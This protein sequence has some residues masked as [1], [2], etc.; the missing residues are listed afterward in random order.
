MRYSILACSSVIFICI[1]HTNIRSRSYRSCI[2]IILMMCIYRTSFLT[3]LVDENNRLF[4]WTQFNRIHHMSSKAM[5]SLIVIPTRF[6]TWKYCTGSPKMVCLCLLR[7]IKNI[8]LVYRGNDQNWFLV[9]PCI[10]SNK[11]FWVLFREKLFKFLSTLIEKVFET[12]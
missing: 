5:L 8:A 7:S 1:W 10:N 2:E 11:Y 9:Y 4:F 6:F 12:I 3:K